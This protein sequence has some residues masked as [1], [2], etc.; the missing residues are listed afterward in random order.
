[1]DG[2]VQR[3]NWPEESNFRPPD[4][5]NRRGSEDGGIGGGYQQGSVVMLRKAD[6]V[7]A[8]FISKGGLLKHLRHHSLSELWLKQARRRRPACF[9]HCSHAIGSCWQE[10]SFHSRRSLSA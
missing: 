3:Q 5:L 9:I 1:M 8:Y 6:P 2:I 7:K 10:G 4:M